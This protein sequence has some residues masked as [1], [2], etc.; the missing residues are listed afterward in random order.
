MFTQHLTCRVCPALSP[1]T[2]GRH[3]RDRQWGE[4]CELNVTQRLTVQRGSTV[5]QGHTSLSPW[6]IWRKCRRYEWSL[7]IRSLLPWPTVLTQR[8]RP[9]S[10][11]LPGGSIR[12]RPMLVA[13]FGGYTDLLSADMVDWWCV[14]YIGLQIFTLWQKSMVGVRIIFDGVLYSKFY[15]NS[16]NSVA[17][18]YVCT[19][20]CTGT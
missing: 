13:V 18:A 10:R 12:S 4:R 17:I 6:V 3:N 5:F 7:V 2:S 14:L 16:Y 20:F 8:P 1:P 19:K 9:F 15:S 11:R